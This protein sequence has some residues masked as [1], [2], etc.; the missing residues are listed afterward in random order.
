[1]TGG[2][3]AFGTI[4]SQLR[5]LKERAD[6]V[7]T[8]LE[9][10]QQLL[11]RRSIRLPSD[12]IDRLWNL[13]SSID[14]LSVDTGRCADAADATAPPRRNHRPHQL[15][16]KNRS[17]AHPGDGHRHQPDA[18]RTRLYRAEESRHWRAGVQGG[19]GLERRRNSGGRA[20]RQLVDHQP[21]RGNWRCSA[22]HGRRRRRQP[23]RQREHRRLQPAQRLG[24][25]AE[26][27]RPANRRCLLRQPR[28]G[29][30]VQ[31]KRAESVDQLW[32]AGGCGDRKCPTCSKKSARRW[33]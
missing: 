24:G 14:K 27:A 23:Q 26:G 7:K 30:L 13:R 2:T 15:R 19:A 8:L 10:Q 32:P 29:W 22:D 4:H 20:H 1:M 9:Q 5:G 11:R 18:S 17:G 16:A 31:R 25:A 6:E 28:H 33:R 21:G 12:A 3:S